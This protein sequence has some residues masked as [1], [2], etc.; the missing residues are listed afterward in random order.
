MNLDVRVLVVDDFEPWRAYV[1]SVVDRQPRLRNLG[2]A[3]DGF[4][5]LQKANSLKPDLVLLDVGLPTLSGIAIARE[6]SKT[7]PDCKIL[8]L[9]ENCSCDLA[10][11]AFRY[12]ACGYVVKRHAATELLPAIQAVLDGRQFCGSGLTALL[13]KSG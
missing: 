9:T 13:Y 8:F 6:L 3:C 12:G 4:E 10:E 5:A 11:Q 2:E 1:R 7:L